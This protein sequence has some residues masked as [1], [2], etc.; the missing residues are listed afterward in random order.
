MATRK[1]VQF[2]I[3]G[4]PLDLSD[5]VKGLDTYPRETIRY[6]DLGPASAPDE[7]TPLDIGRLVII[8]VGFERDAELLMLERGGTAPWHAVSMGHRLEEASPNSA[9][10]RRATL[11]YEHFRQRGNRK[12]KI[13]GVQDAK[14]SKLMHMKRPGFFPILDS[15][16]TKLYSD[17]ARDAY[18]AQSASF[19]RD[20]PTYDRLY[21]EAIRLDLVTDSNRAA[22]A[23]L[24]SRL[25]GQ[26]DSDQSRAEDAA[27]YGQLLI[28]TDLR[29]L[30]ILSWLL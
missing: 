21:W 14:I 23:T 10:Y 26:I 13:H 6:Y 25:Q 3:A 16:V 8:E 18:A 9:L 1:P 5:A 7:I 4:R 20:H 2:T 29:L 27:Y 11:L 17:Q 22:L 28:L 12:S 24:R 30:D 19:R 15:R